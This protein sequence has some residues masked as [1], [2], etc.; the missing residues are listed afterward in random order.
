MKIN[1]REGVIELEDVDFF[2]I[3]RERWQNGTV[4]AARIKK[5]LVTFFSSYHKEADEYGIVKKKYNNS[6]YTI[7]I[8]D[9]PK[10]RKQIYQLLKTHGYNYSKKTGINGGTPIAESYTIRQRRLAP[11]HVKERGRC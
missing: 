6:S 1:T 11:I 8:K 9:E 2:Y 3:Y 10:L 4:L 7:R 5:E